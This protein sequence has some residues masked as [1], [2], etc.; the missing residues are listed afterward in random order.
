MWV[1]IDLDASCLLRSDAGQ[2]VTSSANFP[3]ELAEYE[4]D[5]LQSN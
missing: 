1:L 4:L 5:K 2:K 3:P